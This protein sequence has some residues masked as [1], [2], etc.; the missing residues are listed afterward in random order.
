MEE[1]IIITIG[2]QYGSGGR[3]IGRRLSEKLGV[4]FYDKELIALAARESGMS[5]EVFQQVD[6]KAG[7]SFLYSLSVGSIG[8]ARFQPLANL[9]FNDQLFLFQNQII[10]AIAKRSS[11]IFVGRCANYVLRERENVINVFIH[12]GV[13]ERIARAVSEY[14]HAEKEAADFVAKID[15]SRAAYHNHYTGERWGDAKYYHLSLNSGI[16]LDGCVELIERYTRLHRQRC[17]EK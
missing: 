15:K 1:K 7:S 11:C 16:G 9:N 4:P 12:A 13:E 14:G 10:K 6:E 5:E 17:E 8:G 2:R 3:E